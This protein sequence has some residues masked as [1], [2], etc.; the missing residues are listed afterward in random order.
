MARLQ[1]KTKIRPLQTNDIQRM[2]VFGVDKNKG[3]V[4]SIIM[5]SVKK[6]KFA[7]P[8]SKKGTKHACLVATTRAR[9]NSK[10]VGG[11]QDICHSTNC[12]L[13]LN[14]QRNGLL[15]PQNALEKNGYVFTN[16]NGPLND[17]ERKAKKKGGFSLSEI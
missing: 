14:Q 2:K 7:N 16:V 9:K 6:G 13:I 11:I 17:L 15:L 4:G 3:K 8:V 1:P 5:A 12:V 10:H